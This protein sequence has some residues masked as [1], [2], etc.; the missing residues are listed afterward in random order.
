MPKSLVGKVKNKNFAFFWLLIGGGIGNILLLLY[1]TS[2]WPL[3]VPPA[4]LSIIIAL[5][6]MDKLKRPK[7]PLAIDLFLTSILLILLIPFFGSS[8]IQ[9]AIFLPG[10]LIVLGCVLGIM[11]W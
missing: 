3:L 8:Q 2:A 7:I 4:V 11:N 9:P 6:M 1:S 10:I 5:T